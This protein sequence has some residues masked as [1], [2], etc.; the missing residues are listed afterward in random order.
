MPRQPH[1]RRPLGD[2]GNNV[3][4]PPKHHHHL[5]EKER[6]QIVALKEEGIP[7]S[8]ISQKYGIHS[9][10]I[11]R[12][13]QRDKNNETMA[14]RPVESPASANKDTILPV[15]KEI[16]EERPFL[17]RKQ[18]KDALANENPE[19]IVSERT[20]S[21]WMPSLKLGSHIARWVTRLTAVHAKKRL[22]WCQA[23]LHFSVDDW[24]TV[25]FTDESAV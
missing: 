12:V 10:T 1:P 13:M 23:R 15:I 2:I 16:V 18:I 17:T 7:D 9:S 4:P 5:S 3:D 11:S 6:F 14:R 25:L 20:I 22:E 21:R 8:R 19:F 24:A